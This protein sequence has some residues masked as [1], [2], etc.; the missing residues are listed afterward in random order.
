MEKGLQARMLPLVLQVK[1]L[2]KCDMWTCFTPELCC[3]RSVS[4]AGLQLSFVKLSLQDKDLE[5]QLFFQSV[6]TSVPLLAA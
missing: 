3:I 5:S 4:N 6:R 1:V 2:S